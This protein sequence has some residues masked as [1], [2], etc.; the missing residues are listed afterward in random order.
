M[1]DYLLSFVSKI[2][3]DFD[4]KNSILSI[5]YKNHKPITLKQKSLQK[6]LKDLQMDD[7]EIMFQL[8]LEIL[9]LY[10]CTIRL[11]KN[12]IEIQM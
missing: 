7:E 4:S 11:K 1:C 9:E 10:G 12:I 3:F 2:Q 5:K 8:S 6:C